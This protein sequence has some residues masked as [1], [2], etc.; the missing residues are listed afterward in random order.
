M[1]T[2]IFNV[3]GRINHRQRESFR[4]SSEFNCDG[5]HIEVRNS[6]KTGTNEY[7]QVVITPI[8]ENHRNI[9]SALAGQG[10]DGIFE[11]SA[12]GFIKELVNGEEV[13]IADC[14]DYNFID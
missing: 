8:S 1:E 7:T 6:D 12:V 10:S 3:Y 5:L 13:E 14:N 11:N 2:R 9:E 4:T